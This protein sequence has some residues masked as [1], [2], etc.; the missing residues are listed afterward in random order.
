MMSRN[1]ACLLK[2][3]VLLAAATPALATGHAD[4]SVAARGRYIVQARTAQVATQEV[5][6]VGGLPRRE[7]GLIGAVAAELT[8]AQALRL[9]ADST[10]HVYA[11]RSVSMQKAAAK[12]A[13]TTTNA[14]TSGTDTGTGPGPGTLTTSSL[15][16]AIQVS[17]AS[18]A[19]NTPPSAFDSANAAPSAPTLVG[20]NL[21][22][23]AKTTGAGITIAMLDSGFTYSTKGTLAYDGWSRRI[24]ATVDFAA[25][26][27]GTDVTDLYGHGTQITSVAG[28][29]AQDSSG[30]YYGVAP[31][32]NFVIVRAFQSD[33]SGSY[34]N[35]ISGLDWI[36]ANK[37]RYNI[38]IVNLSLGATPQSYYWDDPLNQAVMRT[39]KAGIVVVVSAGNAGPV[40]QSI[41]VPGNVPYV[42]TVGAM[43]DNHTPYAAGDDR[44]ASF[45][46]A[47]PTFEGFAKPEMVAPGGHVVGTMPNTATLSTQI[48]GSVGA[49]YTL[50]P[51]SGTSQAAAVTSGA[52]ALL[53]QRQPTLSPD[54]VKCKLMAGAAPAVTS[55]GALAYSV[56]Q[57]GAGLVNAVNTVNTTATGCANQGLDIDADL[58]GT[59]HF[60]GAANQAADGSFYM[61]N[62]ENSTP[63][64]ADPTD[65]YS[66]AVAFPWGQGYSWSQAYTWSKAYTWSR[67]YT[68]SKAYTWS[69]TAVWSQAYTWSRSINWTDGAPPGTISSQSLSAPFPAQEE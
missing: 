62:M 35:V 64:A 47:G 50:F 1:V 67:A 22:H 32:A 30:R 58:A 41:D 63:Y 23:T 66:W 61:M 60:G 34:S 53:L 33:G 54:E 14:V 68:W 26:N 52:A 38:R 28:S 12:T 11:D 20:A 21:L 37:A 10:L 51:L 25:S 43:T 9:G 39:W 57:Q 15:V 45:S 42:I 65:G 2:T 69:R 19:T 36:V 6:S 48:F 55:S 46:S 18:A 5:R 40:P 7:L 59:A 49:Q 4:R 29:A 16:P 24:L 27:G 31:G 17:K 56:F 13:A 44:L 3:A 8:Q